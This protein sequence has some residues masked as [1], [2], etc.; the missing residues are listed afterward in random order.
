MP[1][2][3]RPQ[4]PPPSVLVVTVDR[5][6]LRTTVWMELHAL[7]ATAGRTK[8]EMP[9]DLEGA[10]R[11]YEHALA[12]DDR[13]EALAG[14]TRA[15]EACADEKCARAA[16]AGTPFAAPFTL[17]LPGFVARHWA[18]RAA[19]ARAG[20]EAARTAMGP[21]VDGIAKRVAKDLGFEWPD[22][23]PPVDIVTDAPPAGRAAPVRAILGLR[24]N[25]CFVPPKP[26]ATEKLIGAMTGATAKEP[27]PETPRMHD[28]RIIDCVLVYG[29]LR[30]GAKSAMRDALVGELG[31]KE[32]ERAYLLMTVHAVAAVVTNWEPK[33]V[34]VLRRS[35]MSV[36]TP[37]MKWLALH[38]AE[39]MRGEEAT[40]FAKRFAAE[41]RAGVK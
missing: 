23:A 21:E 41:L 2:R 26:D 5:L 24:G 18:D 40:T 19:T 30:A 27:E 11:G 1:P 34:S 15:L 3:L 13:D 32:G 39:R 36:E 16:L 25:V 8:T 10:A 29:T 35:A 38:W 6:A 37:A 28:A 9:D 7:L 22:A 31:E 14:A 12:G 20:V 4:E 17:A 33:H